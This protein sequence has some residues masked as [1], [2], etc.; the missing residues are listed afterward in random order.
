MYHL[1]RHQGLTDSLTGHSLCPTAALERAACCTT[2][3][4]LWQSHCCL[5][6]LLACQKGRLGTI[7][8]SS[9]LLLWR[10]VIHSTSSQVE[11]YEPRIDS[12]VRTRTRTSNRVQDEG[13]EDDWTLLIN[14]LTYEV[15]LYKFIHVSLNDTVQGR[16]ILRA[17][18]YPFRLRIH[19]VHPSL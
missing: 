3:S 4:A 18:Y 9:P 5:L 8:W 13:V 12:V 1:H 16:R 11:F 10:C 14:N 2:R 17:H 6:L 7:A 19:T 15:T